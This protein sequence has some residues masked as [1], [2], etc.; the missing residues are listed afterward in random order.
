MNPQWARL[1][2]RWQIEG[3]VGLTPSFLI[4]ALRE[5]RGVVLDAPISFAELRA[6]LESMRDER[7]EYAKMVKIFECQNLRQPVAALST[8]GSGTVL[9]GHNHQ[10]QLYVW[11]W[12]EPERAVDFEWLLQALW[13]HFRI[14]I[15]SGRFSYD[16]RTGQFRAFDEAD[17]QFIQRALE[18]PDDA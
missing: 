2:D 4:G 3:H 6:L 16:R 8:D 11:P 7:L 15:C 13:C 18:N 12:F 9:R 10:S 17:L 5:P 14:S 1:V